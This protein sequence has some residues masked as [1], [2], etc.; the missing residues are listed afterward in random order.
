[1]DPLPTGVEA[2]NEAIEAILEDISSCLFYHPDLSV[3]WEVFKRLRPQNPLLQ[4]YLWE[5]WVSLTARHPPSCWNA[6]SMAR[7][8]DRQIAIL[9]NNCVEGYESS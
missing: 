9:T 6:F 1:M 4:R 7:Q 5:Q 8:F 2:R 3:G